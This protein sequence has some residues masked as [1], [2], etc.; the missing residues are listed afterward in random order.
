MLDLG[1]WAITFK[2]LVPVHDQDLL[3]PRDMVQRLALDDS[4]TPISTQ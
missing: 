2:W 4:T 3:D 1:H